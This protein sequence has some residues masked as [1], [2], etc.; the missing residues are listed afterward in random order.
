MSAVHRATERMLEDV[1]CFRSFLNTGER[2]AALIGASLDTAASGTI[3]PRVVW[4]LALS[5]DDDSS[6]LLTHNSQTFRRAPAQDT[7]QSTPPNSRPRF[8]NRSAARR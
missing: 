6:G 7:T 8:P 5:A 4:E 2:A 3:L 1:T